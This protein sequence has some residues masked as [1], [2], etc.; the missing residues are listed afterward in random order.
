MLRTLNR[1]LLREPGLAL[2]TVCLTKMTPTQGAAELTVTLAGHLPPMLIG[3][4]GGATSIGRPGLMLGVTDATKVTETP[5]TM[6]AGQTLLLYTDGVTEA[7]RSSGPLGEHGLRAIC[8]D[9]SA[10][11]VD[12]LLRDIEAAAKT[13]SGG[14]LRDDLALLAARLEDR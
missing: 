12:D 4:R 3:R 13:H 11:P 2:C 14:V 7:G 5:V 10:A 6:D 1:A 8:R 9:A